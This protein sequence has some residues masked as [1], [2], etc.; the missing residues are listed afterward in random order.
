MFGFEPG[1]QGFQRHVLGG[2]LKKMIG[3]V[4]VHLEIMTMVSN[5][6]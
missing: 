1:F 6:E 3:Y 2:C 4:V 5:I